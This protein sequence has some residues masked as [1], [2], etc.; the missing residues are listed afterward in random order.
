[1]LKINNLN[2]CK[3]NR[4]NL[5]IKKNLMVAKQLS[6]NLK[7][8]VYF[9]DISKNKNIKKILFVY[10]TL[11]YVVCFGFSGCSE[12]KTPRL[13]PLTKVSGLISDII[14]IFT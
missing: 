12:I 5:I 10:H 7:V 4:A 6:Y 9:S 13:H 14:K 2:V 11:K 1:M 8:V 3:E